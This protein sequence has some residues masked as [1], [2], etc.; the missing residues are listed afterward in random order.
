MTGRR[1]AADVVRISD[2]RIAAPAHLTPEQS[3][4][5]RGIVDSLPADFFRP[6]D[7]PLLAAYCVASSFYK[8]AAADIERRGMVL[9]DARG[10]EYVNPSHQLLTSQAASMAQ[11]AQKLRLCPSARVMGKLAN[12]LAGGPA[13]PKRPWEFSATR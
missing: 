5:W 13:L 2:A 11:M 3:E 6:G 12:K 7:V 9:K 10:R 4:E 8:R 1:K